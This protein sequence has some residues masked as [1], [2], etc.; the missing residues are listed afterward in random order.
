M[1][2]SWFILDLKL[3]LSPRFSHDLAILSIPD[4]GIGLQNRDEM[5]ENQTMIDEEVFI[6]LIELDEDGSTEFL[7]GVA[8]EWF[9]QAVETFASMDDA[10]CVHFT[11]LIPPIKPPSLS[12][13]ISIGHCI[14]GGHS[15][16]TRTDHNL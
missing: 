2:V 15:L 12:P 13:P 4:D 3:A 9:D 14:I 6:Q 11:L 8:T 7:E 10:L 5:L 1:P 16:F